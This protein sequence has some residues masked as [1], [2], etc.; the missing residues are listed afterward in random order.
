MNTLTSQTAIPREGLGF[1]RLQMVLGSM[2]PLFLFL[3]IRG[4]PVI[5]G[6]PIISDTIYLSIC[7]LLVGLPAA[8]LAL[9]INRA[10]KNHD[11]KELVIGTSTD[12]RDHLIAYLFAV[13]IPLYQNN[14]TNLRDVFA[15]VA[16]IAF[17]VFLF[18]HMNLHYMNLV[19]AFSGYRVYTIETE[20]AN[21]SFSGRRPFILITKRHSLQSQQKVT[22][23]RISDT[24]FI[25]YG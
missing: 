19:F 9:R 14:Y 23:R 24:V 25:E 10:G 7:L 13:V 15:E 21:N 17:I 5:D 6:K 1:M 12:H 2:A 16:I 22:A 18:I 20:A 4:V 3:A 8:F 11:T